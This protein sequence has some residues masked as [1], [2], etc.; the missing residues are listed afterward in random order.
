VMNKFSIL[1]I[2][3]LGAAA[4]LC[5]CAPPK[6]KQFE[7]NDPKSGETTF[8]SLGQNGDKDSI[9]VIDKKTGLK[10]EIFTKFPKHFPIFIAPIVGAKNL[11]ISA[12]T[13]KSP[14][15]GEYKSALIIKFNHNDESE[16]I[17]TDYEKAFANNGFE[18]TQA[19]Q[20]GDYKLLEFKNKNKSQDIFLNLDKSKDD[21]IAAVEISFF[22]N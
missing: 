15:I 20:L 10:T 5:A 6:P 13:P 22:Q 21:N 4:F 1:A 14:Q 7:L 11:E 3:L 8:V 16:K 9:Q 12:S 17:I 19:T 18:K 2:S